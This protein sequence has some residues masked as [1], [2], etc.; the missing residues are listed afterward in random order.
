MKE[1]IRN[2]V[3]VFDLKRNYATVKGEIAEALD[4]VLE[5]Q[6]FILGEEV[7]SF[8]EE[9]ARYLDVGEAIGCASG[10]D[11]LLLALMALD[12]KPGDEV[13]TTPFTFFATASAIV[14]L[15]GTPVFCDVDPATYNLD[16]GQV[17]SKVTSKTKV[18]LP[19][20]LFGQMCPLEEIA[21]P[22]RERG[23]A[24]VEDCAQA[25]GALRFIESRSQGGKTATT[26]SRAGAVGDVGCFSF[27]PTKNLG[28]YGDGG[29]ATVTEKGAPLADR[30]RS[31]RV[32]GGRKTYY[33]DEVGLNSRLDAMQAAILRVRLRHVEEWNERRRA[34]ADRYRLLLGEA[35]LLDRVTPPMELAGGRHVYHQYVVRVPRRDALIDFLAEH[36]VGTRVYYPLNLHLQ[37]CFEFLGYGKGAFPVAETLTDEVLA[38]PMFPEIRPREQERV[39]E[40]LAA[41]FAC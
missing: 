32:H 25:F 26:I 21:G 19:V 8:E 7:A 35:G 28:C 22:L 20:H 14:R 4:R 3:P 9:V 41:F 1:E 31:L 40:V 18:V 2:N 13:I 30:I 33:H 23:I 17:L 10:T 37:P 11:A 24:M 36:G 6:L 29:M 34:A 15:G 27:F 12:V 39:I 38:L 16:M 5:S